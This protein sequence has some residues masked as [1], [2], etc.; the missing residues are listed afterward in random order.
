MPSMAFPREAQLQGAC[1]YFRGQQ[2]SRLRCV[3]IAYQPYTHS[4]S[5]DDP[6][7]SV[8]CLIFFFLTEGE[9]GPY[10]LPFFFPLIAC[11]FFQLNSLV[12]RKENLHTFKA[13]TLLSRD[14]TGLEAC[15]LEEEP[16]LPLHGLM[17]VSCW[18][19]CIP[20]RENLLWMPLLV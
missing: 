2:S 7:F 17:K 9:Y 16:S 13:Y 10:S 8:F 18:P 11:T 20:L 4:A 19:R 6:T 15:C 12:S 1:T 14:R 3:L 5:G